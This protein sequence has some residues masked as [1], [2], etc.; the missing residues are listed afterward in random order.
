MIADIF[1]AIEEEPNFQSC[2][3]CGSEETIGT[4]EYLNGILYTKDGHE[5]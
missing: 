4:G 3:N 2:P 5:I 1:F